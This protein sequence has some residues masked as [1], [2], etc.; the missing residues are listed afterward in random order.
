MSTVI[1]R[2]IVLDTE[3]TGMNKLGIH[4]EGHNIIEI[5]A[6]E[7]INR[8]LTG[9]YFHVYIKPSRLIDPEAFE[10]HGISNKFLQNKP[11]FAKIVDEFLDF[12]RGAE[13]IIHNAPFDVGFI[14]YEFSK[15][16][17]YIP[18]IIN[19]CQVTDSLLLARKLFPGKRNSLDAL[20]DRYHINKS[21]RILHS[22]L[23]D[24][25]ILAEVYMAMTGGQ[26][27]LVFSVDSEVYNETYISNIKQI[28]RS[29]IE[30]N[31][32]YANKEEIIAHEERLDFIEKKTGKI[33]IW[34]LNDRKND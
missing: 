31:V 1:T 11:N 23:L 3:T 2:Q 12:I 14:N 19:F 6:V 17:K 29:I 32:I 15:L 30:L 4:Y 25:E 27:L 5:G 8:H 7:V 20:C 16:N 10:I 26:T 13:L 28:N 21:K 22:A 34:R 9:R 33:S 18:P 24:A